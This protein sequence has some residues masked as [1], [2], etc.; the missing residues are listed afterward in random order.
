M[1]CLHAERL[2][3]LLARSPKR[4]SRAISIASSIHYQD[5]LQPAE[6]RWNPRQS[7]TRAGWV[8]YSAIFANPRFLAQR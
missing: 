6:A 5:D 7:V 8:N 1:A 2:S 3:T 4:D